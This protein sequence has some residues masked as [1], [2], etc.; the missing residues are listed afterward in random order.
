[1]N[2]GSAVAADRRRRGRIEILGLR[3][4]ARKIEPRRV[5]RCASTGALTA[6]CARLC[7][8][9]TRSERVVFEL[10][11]G[12]R[13]LV[14]QP[15]LDDREGGDAFLIAGGLGCR[16]LLSATCAGGRTRRTCA[17]GRSPPYGGGTGLRP[18]LRGHPTGTP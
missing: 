14:H 13:S 4:R 3:S 11:A 10:G 1:M 16:I 6:R 5:P 15:T 12:E 17:G 18:Q 9:T 7:A 2:T 8:K